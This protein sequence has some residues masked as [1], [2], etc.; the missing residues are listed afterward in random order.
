MLCGE[1]RSNDLGENDGVEKIINKNFKKS[2]NKS[3]KKKILDQDDD[4]L[5]DHHTCT[6]KA[7]H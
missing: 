1:D 2:H 6:A 4:L 5:T 3:A 7:E